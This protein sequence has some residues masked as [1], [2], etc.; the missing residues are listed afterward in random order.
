MT[1]ISRWRTS[2]AAMATPSEVREVLRE[3]ARIAAGM[4]DLADRVRRA[5]RCY[6]R[7][8][9]DLEAGKI[10]LE[11]CGARIDQLEDEQDS[12]IG[13]DPLRGEGG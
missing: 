7:F 3:P 13:K 9:E 5:A 1:R 4:R 6:E 11:N 2:G 12:I 10:T 8:A